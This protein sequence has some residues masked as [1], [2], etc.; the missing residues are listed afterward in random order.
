MGLFLF[1]ITSLQWKQRQERTQRDSG[2]QGLG[3]CFHEHTLRHARG[4]A[5]QAQSVAGWKGGMIEEF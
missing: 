5:Q 4:A 1:L 2:R 3:E